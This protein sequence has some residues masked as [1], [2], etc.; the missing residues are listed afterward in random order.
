VRLR[1]FASRQLGRQSLPG[2]SLP[3][4]F[5][6]RHDP[7]ARVD[8]DHV[9]LVV[10]AE[11]AGAFASRVRDRRPRPAVALDERAPLLRR[12]RDVDPE[13]GV[14]R[15]RLLELGVGDRLAVAR[16]SPRRPD[17]DEHRPAAEVR[18][19]DP[20]SIERDALDRRRGRAV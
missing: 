17:V 3:A 8:H 13:I 4:P 18:E 7:P 10:R 20:L 14:L 11:R 19:R 12:V 6:T 5:E 9:R 15:V 1:T 16:A 2:R